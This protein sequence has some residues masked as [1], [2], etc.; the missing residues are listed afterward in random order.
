MRAVSSGDRRG[1]ERRKDDRRQDTGVRGGD[2]EGQRR[3]RQRRRVERRQFFRIVYP[4]TLV[5][6]IVNSK[7]RVINLSQRGIVLRWEGKKDECPVDLTLGSVINLQ[8]QFHDGETL[9]LKMT[10][11]RCQS[12]RRSHM[13][14]Y[15]GTLEPALTAPRVSKEERYLLR[16]VPDFCR[17]EWHSDG[18][19]LEE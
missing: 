19:L 17:V 9:N 6:K 4:P 2:R 18:P 3:Q 16:T 11:N 14:V 13:T 1:D 8:I 7:F 12:E 10:I 5:P 15:A